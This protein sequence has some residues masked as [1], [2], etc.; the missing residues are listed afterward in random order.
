[1]NY[2]K[3]LVRRVAQSRYGIWLRNIIRFRTVKIRLPNDL[4]N[5]SIS[6]AF[7]WRTHDGYVTYFRFSD[8]PKIYFNAEGTQVRF[9]FFDRSGNVVKEYAL[10]KVHEFNELVI[11]K[12]FL[13]NM[14]D[15]GT[16]SV[17]HVF[18]NKSFSDVKI[19]NRCYV[20]FSKD[21]DIPSFVHGNLYASYLNPQTNKIMSDI[22]IISYRPT[23]YIIQ[24]NFAAFDHIELFFV[25]PTTYLVWVTIND[26]KLFLKSG[27]CKIYPIEPT[28]LIKIVSNCCFPRPL[29]FTQKYGFF[30][31]FHS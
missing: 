7:P 23:T 25:N 15:Y 18:D 17:F 14:E 2:L 10:N 30:D 3:S 26:H 22:V 20:G 5:Y 16:F 27:E 11:D 21:N 12:G 19:I 4:S 31:C 24:K 13:N 9:L 29:I 6:D 28:D 8:I 1:M